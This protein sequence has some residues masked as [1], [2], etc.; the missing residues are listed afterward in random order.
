MPVNLKKLRALME[1]KSEYKVAAASG[2]SRGTLRNVLDESFD[3]K[4]S[5]I[6][7]LAAGLRAM[8]ETCSVKDLLQ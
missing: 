7:K 6:E 8:G 2:I 1:N 4:I 3:A 5:T